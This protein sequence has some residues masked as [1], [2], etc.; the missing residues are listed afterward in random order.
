ML[1][2]INGFIVH[3]ET[4]N[5]G[6]KHTSD[7]YRRD[8]TH[9]YDFLMYEK[10][11]HWRNVDQRLLSRYL[12]DLNTIGK[13]HLKKSSIARKLSSLRSFYTYLA[14]KNIVSENPVMLLK[15]PKKDKALPDFFLFDELNNLFESFDL[16]E[17]EGMRNRAMFELMYAS[18]LRVSET[19]NLTMNQIDFDQ[20]ILRFIGKGSK[21]RMVPF[22]SDAGDLLRQ[23]ITKA[24]PE[25]MKHL[26]HHY[27]F[28]NHHG[29]KL[30]ARGL[31]FILN[32]ACKKAGL[33]KSVHPH[34]LRHS[35]ATHLLDNGAD[36]RLVQEL[37]G[38]KNLSTTQIYT[39]VTLDR[40]KET[41][42]KA[43][44]RVK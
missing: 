31:E 34:M 6:S 44:P 8:L 4:V 13:Q 16:N 5:S 38:H 43:H 29:S 24:R 26:N 42:L 41:Y 12:A 19:I 17:V 18:G 20:R 2:D 10:I 22:Y 23:Y 21:D 32:S 3:I 9:F 11:E 36:L 14:F 27:V 7:A 37:L 33:Q 35:F 39:H 15:T 40:L 1:E 30:S 28:V 25:L